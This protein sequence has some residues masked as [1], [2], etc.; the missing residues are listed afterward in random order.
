MDNQRQPVNSDEIDLGQLFS[1]IGGFFRSIGLGFLRFLA[2]V[3]RVPLE[4][5]MV[6]MGLIVASVVGGLFYSIQL[7]KSFYESTLILS[8]EYLNKRL[9]DNAM[10]KLN[11]LAAE[12]DKSG[13]ARAL[14]LPDSMAKTI[15]RFDAK[16]FIE[17]QE[18]LL[19]LEV[20]KEQLQR[21]Q[22]A[23]ENKLNR[24]ITDEVIEQIEIEN[25]NAFEIKVR[26]TSPTVIGE[27]ERAVVGYFRE[28]EY[29]KKRIEISLENRLNRKA[30]LTRDLQRLDS[31]KFVIYENY[32]TIAAQTRQGSNNVILSDK[33]VTGPVEVYEQALLVNEM[34][35]EV[36]REVYL[37]PDFEIIDGFT[38]FSEPASVST[39]KI[40]AISILFGIAA[41]YALVALAGFNK[42]LANL[43]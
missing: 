42:Y 8:S 18:V 4:N 30:K 27:L 15:I 31:L 37:Q 24:K 20:L 13:L 6:F 11:Q 36:N 29:I 14:H 28:N 39:L 1:K 32:K 25:R 35:E 38:E 16:P 43:N 2:M 5:R 22:N 26:A 34:L 23:E 41:G 21:L 10:D 19:E 40:V 12:R 33:P 7:R 3:R 17:D 9:V